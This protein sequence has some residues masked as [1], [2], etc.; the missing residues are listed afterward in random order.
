MP[1]SEEA[2]SAQTRRS[3]CWHPQNTMSGP[4]I[5]CSAKREKRAQEA[6]AQNKERTVA[7][8]IIIYLLMSRLDGG[9]QCKSIH[10]AL[11]DTG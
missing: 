4:R 9:C 3:V 1:R 8:V 11:Q 7:I 6:A 2:L 10:A 5:S